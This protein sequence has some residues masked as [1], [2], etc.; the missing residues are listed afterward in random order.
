MI[1]RLWCYAETENGD[2]TCYEFNNNRDVF[3]VKVLL[4]EGFEEYKG[5]EIIVKYAL[6]AV[7]SDLILFGTAKIGD[8][9]TVK[10]TLD[11]PVTASHVFVTVPGSDIVKEKIELYEEIKG[12]TANYYPMHFDTILDENYYLETVSVF[13]S[14]VGYS[15]YSVFTSL[16]GKDFQ[17][18]A[19]KQDNKPCDFATGDV[20]NAN[21]RE[22]RVI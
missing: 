9:D 19:T 7:L 15:N 13:T 11:V 12:E 5:Q 14:E 8:T 4:K 22:A 20:F 21:G 17:F 1:E 3:A 10:I 2:T 6:N 16:D 18:L